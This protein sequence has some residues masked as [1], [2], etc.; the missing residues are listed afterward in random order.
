YAHQPQD[1]P[2]QLLEHL[3]QTPDAICVLIVDEV[4]DENAELLREKCATMPPGV[5]LILIG[6]DASGRPQPETVQIE[7]LTEDLLIKAINAITPGLPEGVAKEIAEVCERSPKL[8]VLIA[9]RISQDPSLVSP[10]QRLKDR[11]IEGVLERYL[12]IGEEDILAL[13][14]IA[15]LERLGW[16]EGVEQESVVLYQSLGMDPTLSRGRVEQL[17]ERYGIAPLA[18]RFRYISPGILGDYLAARRLKGW[19]ADGLEA[20]FDQISPTMSESFSRRIRCL[21]AVINNREIVE[22][23][24]FGDRGPFRNIE[25]LEQSGMAA[26]LKNL[27][28][29]FPQG[30]I[31]ALDRIIGTATDD[32]LRASTRCRRDLVWALEELLWSEDTFEPTARLVLRL[33]LTENETWSNSATGLWAATFQTM[34]GHTAAGLEPRF[35]VLK[36]AAQDANPEAR[37]LG[38]VALENALKIGHI[39]RFGNPPDDVPGMPGLI[40]LNRP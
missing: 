29:A 30:A 25:E 39:T 2:G 31:R 15:L 16:T 12:D 17:H 19:T 32:Q 37:H 23:A 1:V 3:R 36:R 4:D 33:A 7:G 26:L 21:S 22:V 27:A 14:A 18:G 11:T 40:Y 8:A 9:K 35:R 6:I 24:V 34:L 5:G 28:G 10:S 20:F 13:S 38:A